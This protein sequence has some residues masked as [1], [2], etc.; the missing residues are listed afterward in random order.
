MCARRCP[1]GTHCPSRPFLQAPH[2]IAACGPR[3]ERHQ[4]TLLGGHCPAPRLELVVEVG[5]WRW[6]GQGRQ[7]DSHCSQLLPQAC[8]SPQGVCFISCNSGLSR[9]RDSSFGLELSG[10]GLWDMRMEGRTPRGK[11]PGVGGE[12]LEL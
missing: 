12:E 11:Q 5:R 2:A 9:G 4:H 7:E 8:M 3:M 6:G 1:G 10:L